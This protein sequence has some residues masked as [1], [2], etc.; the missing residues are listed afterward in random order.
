MPSQLVL[1]STSPRRRE[2]LERVGFVVKPM[3]VAI[4]ET[5]YTEESRE[6]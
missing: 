1:A 2:L 6:I 4:D 5:P 3:S